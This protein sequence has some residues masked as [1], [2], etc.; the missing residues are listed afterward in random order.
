MGNDRMQVAYSPFDE[1]ALSD[2]KCKAHGDDM[3]HAC[4]ADPVDGMLDP[5][6]GVD[7]AFP[8]NVE[9][10]TLDLPDLF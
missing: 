4:G 8:A 1:L 5:I 3:K 6:D 7:R 2:A 10:P 9:E